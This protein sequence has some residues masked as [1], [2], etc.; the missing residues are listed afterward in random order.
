MLYQ[1]YQQRIFPHLLN[2][3]MQTSCL[4]DSRR[5]LLMPIR[6]EV[7]E[8]GFG[9]GLN[10]AFYQSVACVYAVEP[11]LK[12][13]HLAQQRISETP[14]QVQHI[15]ACAEK[16]PFAD[17]SMDNI[18][19]TW[20]LCSVADL[21]LTL[22]EIYRVLKPNGTFHLVE[23]V[24]YESHRYMQALQQL[25]TPVQKVIA[26]GCH[27]NRNI[28]MALLSA[29]FKLT[30][31]HYFDADGIPKVGRRMLLARAQKR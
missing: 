8:I 23:H 29:G 6:G 10:L 13:F 27:L 21:N 16:L 17:A 19:S 11:H 2:Q 28:E 25:L 1:F 5:Q 9:T 12:V 30:E 14:F 24:L 4:M 7:L 26:D 15:Q 31:Q 20:T 18:V 3:V 22:A